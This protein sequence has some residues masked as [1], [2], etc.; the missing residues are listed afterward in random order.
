MLRN[1]SNDEKSSAKRAYARLQARLHPKKGATAA[2]KSEKSPGENVTK[3]SGAN[4][5][6]LKKEM[7]SGNAGMQSL[8][9]KNKKVNL[10]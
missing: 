3:L 10:L 8:P 4:T 7:L 2:A 9:T 5:T 6:D 1:G